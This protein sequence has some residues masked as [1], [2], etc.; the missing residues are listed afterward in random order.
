MR[1]SVG[2]TPVPVTVTVG[3]VPDDDGL[4]GL[5]LLPHAA[6]TPTVTASATPSWNI[7]LENIFRNI[8]YTSTSAQ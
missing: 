8:N 7:L 1:A 5:L 2:L 3:T 4:I 6:T